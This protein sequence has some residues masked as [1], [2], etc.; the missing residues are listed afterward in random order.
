MSKEN[1]FVH[2][3]DVVL[4]SHG[5]SVAFILFTIGQWA[6]KESIFLA[7]FRFISHVTAIQVNSSAIYQGVY[8][9]DV[10]KIGLLWQR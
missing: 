8:M 3:L 10:H 6:I 1:E 7:R 4:L 2:V 5:N 9:Y